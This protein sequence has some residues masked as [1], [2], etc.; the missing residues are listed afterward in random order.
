MCQSQ[1]FQTHATNENACVGAEDLVGAGDGLRGVH[2]GDDQGDRSGEG[3][4]Y[5]KYTVK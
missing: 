5:N 1:R 2:L 4:R 3:R